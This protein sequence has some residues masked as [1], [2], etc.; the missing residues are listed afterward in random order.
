MESPG[1]HLKAV[2]NGMTQPTSRF[3]PLPPSLSPADLVRHASVCGGAAHSPRP[4]A[5][6]F[7]PAAHKPQG[8]PAGPGLPRSASARTTTGSPPSSRHPHR[9]PASPHRDTGSPH[10]PDGAPGH[11]QGRRLR[12]QSDMGHGVVQD[13]GQQRRQPGQ[14]KGHQLHGQPSPPYHALPVQ[15]GAASGYQR[16]DVGGSPVMGRGVPGGVDGGSGNGGGSQVRSRPQSPVPG[17]S[18]TQPASVQQQQQQHAAPTNQQ[19]RTEGGPSRQLLGQ[20]RGQQQAPGPRSWA[21]EV[22]DGEGEADDGKAAR[23]EAHK[24]GTMHRE[25]GEWLNVQ[26]GQQQKQQQEVRVRSYHLFAMPDW[27]SDGE[28][29]KGRVRSYHLSAMPD[30]ESDNEER[31]ARKQGTEH[32]RRL[33]LQRGRRQGVEEQ[34]RKEGEEQTGRVR[35]YHLSAVPGW[36]SDDEEQEQPRIA[37]APLSPVLPAAAGATAAAGNRTAPWPPPVA[38]ATAAAG[39]GSATAAYVLPAAPPAPSA[40]PPLPPATRSHSPGPVAPPSA[41]DASVGLNPPALPAGPVTGL[42]LNRGLQP[43][44]SAPLPGPA[45]PH[46]LRRRSSTSGSPASPEPTTSPAPPSPAAPTATTA[47]PSADPTPTPHALS[48]PMGLRPSRSARLGAEMPGLRAS[49]LRASALLGG[50]RGSSSLLL[51]AS[52]NALRASGLLP[53]GLVRRG[54]HGGGLRASIGAQSDFSALSGPQVSKA[55]RRTPC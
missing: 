48:G 25:Q 22:D 12:A 31:E 42:H 50:G 43:F 20:D 5:N 24:Q 2:C 6:G 28:E 47:T 7:H 55:R 21:V 40:K 33:P 19:V 37:L 10:G 29:L 15:S 32:G 34:Q 9:L 35:S 14:G 17:M 36:E 52:H 23:R 4:T 1:F 51:R 46:R 54:S 38:A 49:G 27:E 16:R 13:S 39:E 3:P 8:G 11:M 26:Q 44:S 41:F 45:Q 53:A 18:Q 30:W